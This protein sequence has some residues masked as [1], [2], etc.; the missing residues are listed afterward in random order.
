[1]T[2]TMSVLNLYN[3]LA[4][5]KKIVLVTLAI[6][7][8]ATAG[9]SA[10]MPK[11]Y[12]ASTTLLLNYSGTDT[13]TGAPV[14]VQL[15]SNF[16]ATQA[17]IVASK[18]VA[19]KV[20]DKLDLLN[21]PAFRPEAGASPVTEKDQRV[22]IAEELLEKLE[23]K[24]GRESTTLKLT[25]KATDPEFAALAANTFAA[26]YQ[27]TSSQFKSGPARNATSYFDAQVRAARERV[28]KAQA[29]LSA[30][31]KE[32]GIVNVDSRQDIETSR[33]NEL[34][35]QLVALQA[36]LTDAKSRSTQAQ[37]NASLSPEI[38]S[39]PLIQGLQSEVAKARSQFSYVA[40]RFKDTHPR[41]Q[42]QKAEL[43]KLTAELNRQIA[44]SAGSMT[45]NTAI[46]RQREADIRTALQAQ[47]AKV[48]DINRQRDQ[49]AVFMREIESAQH[50]YDA[51]TQRLSQVK[52]EGQSNQSDVAV[53]SLATIPAKASSPIMMLNLLASVFIGALLGA[54]FALISELLDRRVRSSADITEILDAPL[55]GT[56]HR[57]K[58]QRR[59]ATALRLGLSRSPA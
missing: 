36:Q 15:I 6:T 45:S 50:S 33:L 44:S 20:V 3:V 19:L 37:G 29:I 34:S 56:L 48:L 5:R 52:L 10:H 13:V 51:I 9:L 12:K 32:S 1:M 59:R 55:L 7:V 47:K 57:P 41:Y 58:P 8:L 31:Q 26:E 23:V 42:A 4:A 53:L 17:D 49:L 24:P 27:Q 11:V 22:A 28:E 43:D 46:L 21:R 2:N 18:N 30:F 38:S 40:E 39:N 25:F 35:S 14:P 16:I 54:G